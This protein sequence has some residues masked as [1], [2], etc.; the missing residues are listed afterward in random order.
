ME[1]EVVVVGAGVGGLCAAAKLA[2][3][4]ARVL[5]VE[6]EPQVG[7]RASTVEVDGF[8]LPTGGIALELGGPMQ[9]LAQEVGA[10]Y[11]VR[12]PS[13]GVLVRAG[14]RTI[15]TTSP[16]MRLVVDGVALRAARRGMRLWPR[17]A[18][19]DAA[20]TLDASLRRL[21]GNATVHGMARNFAAG[22]F[23]LNSNEISAHAI[24]TYLTQKGAFRRFGFCPRGT[25]GV[26]EELA[27]VVTRH[28]G[29]VWTAAEVRGIEVEDG[30]ATAVTVDRGGETVRVACDSVV[31]NAGPAATVALLGHDALRA[32]YVSE[33]AARDRPT[34]IIVV[35]IASRGPLVEEAGIMFFAGTTRLAALG[36]YTS[37]CPE[38][39]P[40]GWRLYVAYAVPVPALGPFDEEAELARTLAELDAEC[41]GF[42]QARV[43]RTRVLS[44]DWPAQRA[45]AGHEAPMETP[46]HNVLNVGDGARQYGDGGMQACAV[47]G[48]LAAELLLARG[49]LRAQRPGVTPAIRPPST[50]TSAPLT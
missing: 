48:A 9:R 8:R 13:P 47:T 11:D 14:G 46:L 5:L 49:A 4:G 22:V 43:L 10:R 19:A 42:A 7:G 15:D 2:H 28:G 17:P 18:D 29:E 30:R 34:P 50:T 41:S 36:H 31:S 27:R 12:A 23:G 35:D 24:A 1:T 37:T 25:I 32:A 3:A 21:T 45:T 6:R 40:P 26:M 20:P 38:V 16:G 44:G 39:A 33:I